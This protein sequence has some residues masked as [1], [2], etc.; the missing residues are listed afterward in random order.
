MA[1][2]LQTGH[3]KP[4]NILDL[5]HTLSSTPTCYTIAAKH[6]QWRDAM[7]SEFHALQSQ[8]TW[9]LVPPPPNQNILGCK[10]IYG[11][12][13]HASGNI[14]RYKARLVA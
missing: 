12:K 7:S 13:R 3:L 8:G 2:R 11:I 1:T 6:P 14:A 10:W 9:S 4:Q 5:Q